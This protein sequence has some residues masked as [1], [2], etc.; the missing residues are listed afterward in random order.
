LQVFAQTKTSVKPKANSSSTKKI[1]APVKPKEKEILVEITTDYGT[2]IAKLYNS[3]PLH[4]DNF[5]KLVQQGFY[6]S[7][8]FHRVIKN[9]MIQGGDPTSK[10]ATDTTLLGGTSAFGEDIP[11]EFRDN[12]FHKRGA[13]AAARNNNPLKASS[14]SQFYIVLGKR[15]DSVQLNQIYNS[16]VKNNNPNFV[17]TAA[18]KEIYKRLGGAPFLDQNYTVFG[19]IISGLNV[20]DKIADAP[21]QPGDRP[22]KNIRMKIKLL[23]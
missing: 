8:L 5:I 17:Y 15:Y 6:D 2:M 12:F 9:F 1:I 11:A 7:L 14:P 20:L 16:A 3:T 19:E 18:Q 4:R 22:I 21:T 13:L 23:N 10:Y